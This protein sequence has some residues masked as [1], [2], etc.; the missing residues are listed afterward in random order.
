MT[1]K[2]TLGFQN[3]T[4]Y[5]AG[6]GQLPVTPQFFYSPTSS[7]VSPVWY[8]DRVDADHS[9]RLS[10]VQ[11]AVRQELS[12][13]L[14]T[15]RCKRVHAFEDGE[16][17][18]FLVCIYV[19]KLPSAVRIPNDR[20]WNKR[21]VSPENHKCCAQSLTCEIGSTTRPLSFTFLCLNPCCHLSHHTLC[22]YMVHVCHAYMGIYR[23][24]KRHM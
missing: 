10:A 6:V 3:I 4:C 1:Y 16:M 17:H 14:G 19:F 11:P 23:A 22:F 13:V 24:I 7:T 21:R 15:Q 20:R 18:P 2:L 12:S 5:L 9:P 8:C